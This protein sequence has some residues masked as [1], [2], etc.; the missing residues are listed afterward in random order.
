M[1]VVDGPTPSARKNGFVGFDKRGARIRGKEFTE[2]DL[3][4]RRALPMVLFQ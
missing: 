4:A 1:R 3:L 2:I